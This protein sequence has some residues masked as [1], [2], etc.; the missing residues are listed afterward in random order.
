MTGCLLC[1]SYICG[2]VLVR[3]ECF[4]VMVLCV[5]VCFIEAR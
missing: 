3:R 4:M 1:C 2:A 5:C